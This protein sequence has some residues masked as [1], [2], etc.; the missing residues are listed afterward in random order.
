[1]ND[2]LDCVIVKQSPDWTT[3]VALRQIYTSHADRFY[4]QF[5]T[6]VPAA[7][8]AALVSLR[9]LTGSTGIKHCYIHISSKR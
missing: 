7:A 9:P 3:P 8:P 5:C 1:M 2:C 4:S 6:D